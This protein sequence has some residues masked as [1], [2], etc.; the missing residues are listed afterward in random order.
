M[1]SGRSSHTDTRERKGEEIA[2]VNGKRKREEARRKVKREREEERTVNE[3]T[4]EENLGYTHLGC[5]D[6]G[7]KTKLQTCRMHFF[8][9]VFSK[10]P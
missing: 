1:R 9:N 5:I 8:P 6:C 10:I 4:G 2:G 3:R 7:A